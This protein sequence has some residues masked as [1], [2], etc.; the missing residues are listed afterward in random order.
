MM[1]EDE[2]SENHASWKVPEKFVEKS[3]KQ[4]RWE[5]LETEVEKITDR[6]GK[7][8]ETGIKESVI[9]LKMYEFP[10]RQ[11]CEGH[12]EREH[13]LPYPW[14][15]IV[16][17]A[18]E[19]WREDQEK[20]NAW[21]R[22]NLKEQKK[23]LDLLSEFYQNRDTPL[24]ARIVFDPS[25]ALGGFRI[26]SMGAN[27]MELLSPEERSRTHQLYKKEMEDFTDFLKERFFKE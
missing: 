19:G 23:M 6:L 24:D 26:Q 18:P 22:E 14:V 8:I 5:G 10:T 21:K 13:G 11:S 15:E 7:G 3:E 1:T 17:P 20:K 4:K 27:T 12:P 9:A 16:I 25:G 2:G